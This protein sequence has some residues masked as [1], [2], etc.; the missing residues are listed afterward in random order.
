MAKCVKCGSNMEFSFFE[1][2]AEVYECPKC[3]NVEEFGIN[4]S[5]AEA[6]RFNEETW[7]E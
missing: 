4:N 5:A 3:H 2:G 6:I 7:G 1:D